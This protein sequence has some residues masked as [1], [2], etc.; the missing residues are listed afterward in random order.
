MWD[1]NNFWLFIA[2]KIMIYEWEQATAW[3]MTWKKTQIQMD[4]NL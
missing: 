4:I 3:G 2:Q 1:L